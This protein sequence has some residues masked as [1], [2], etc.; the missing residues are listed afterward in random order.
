MAYLE[1]PIATIT[2][3]GDYIHIVCA[4]CG[5]ACT[6]NYKGLDPSV[7][8]LEIRCPNDRKRKHGKLGTW[9]LWR[10]RKGWTLNPSDHPRKWKRR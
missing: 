8:L 4:K 9:K 10:S 6:M 5:E 3:D 2:P 1:K 7:P